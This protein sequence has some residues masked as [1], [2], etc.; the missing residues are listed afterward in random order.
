MQ[1][2]KDVKVVLLGDSGKQNFSLFLVKQIRKLVN[3][4]FYYRKTIIYTIFFSKAW[5]KAAFSFDL[6]QTSSKIIM[7]QLWEQL[8]WQK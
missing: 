8:L 6:L 1:K 3:F 4:N 2:A 5:A 7:N